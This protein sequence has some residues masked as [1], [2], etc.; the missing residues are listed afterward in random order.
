MHFVVD[1]PDCAHDA[2]LCLQPALR[3]HR[4]SNR[5][6]L[7]AAGEG[8]THV[9]VVLHGAVDLILPDDDAV[10]DGT[11]WVSGGKVVARLGPGESTVERTGR[12]CAVRD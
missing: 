4:A 3:W 11:H 5:R 7:V 12:S 9:H 2:A 10:D 6:V 8:V 1:L